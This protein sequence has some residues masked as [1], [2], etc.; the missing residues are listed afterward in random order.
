MSSYAKFSCC[1]S[2]LI[3]NLILRR[4]AWTRASWN[5]NVLYASPQWLREKDRYIFGK[6][7]VKWGLSSFLA[8]Q[9]PCTLI[10]D[11]ITFCFC[12][13]LA[14]VFI[15]LILLLTILVLI[16]ETMLF[17]IKASN[18]DTWEEYNEKIIVSQMSGKEDLDLMNK[19]SV[20]LAM[21]V[22]VIVE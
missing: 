2:F 21:V 19:I 7:Q 14:I 12:Y 3:T 1:F 13:F 11:E 17:L 9:V 4:P 16:Q 20:E 5:H 18:S 22:C 10:V 8:Q 15:L 6:T